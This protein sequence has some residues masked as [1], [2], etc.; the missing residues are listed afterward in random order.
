VVAEGA[1]VTVP[2]EDR[3]FKTGEA[4]PPPDTTIT[5]GSAGKVTPDVSFKFKSSES[6]S[7]FE[8]ALDS[9]SYGSC[10]SPRSYVGL[11]EGSHTFKVRAVGAGGADPTP[12]ERSFTVVEVDKA[13]SGVAVLDDFGRSEIPLETGE[14]TE[15]AWAEEIG[16]S[17]D[18]KWHGFGANGNH[19]A[20]AYWNPTT[21]SDASA[22][23][24]VSA[25]LGTGP[26]ASGEYLSLW[27]D[28]PSPGSARSGYEARFTCTSTCGSSYKVELSVWSSGTRIVLA[29]KEGVSLSKDTTFVLTETGGKLTI[30]SGTT[31]FSSVI[32]SYFAGYSSG[33]AG[34]EANGGEGTAYDFRAGNV[35]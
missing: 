33:Y 11:G 3:F 16:G 14:W 35:Q 30:W 32:S 8:C 17:W 5:G 18:E 26:I 19:L 10:S 6:G 4:A 13:V 31:S 29:S 27:L 12:A 22:G 7:S 9:G 25:T 23:Q 21:F 34:I 28:M 1:G 15:T 20:G 24:L 2:G